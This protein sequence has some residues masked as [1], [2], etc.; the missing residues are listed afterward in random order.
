MSQLINKIHFRI[1][2]DHFLVKY[3]NLQSGMKTIDLV[4]QRN[5]NKKMRQSLSNAKESVFVLTPIGR[6]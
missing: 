5:K 6:I 1:S 2:K 4:H 3:A